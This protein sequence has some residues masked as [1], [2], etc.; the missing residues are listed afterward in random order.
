MTAVAALS[1]TSWSPLTWHA[2]LGEHPTV[3]RT[4]AREVSRGRAIVFAPTC[5]LGA[6]QPPVTVVGRGAGA[7]RRVVVGVAVGRGAREAR[8]DCPAAAR[9]VARGRGAVGVG[10]TTGDALGVGI[11]AVAMGLVA[12]GVGHG[13][14]DATRDAGKVISSSPRSSAVAVGVV[15][16][17]TAVAVGRLTAGIRVVMTPNTAPPASI[18]PHA[19]TRFRGVSCMTTPSKPATSAW[20][21]SGA[22]C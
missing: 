15:V 19:L 2:L 10:G 13:T 5:R 12:I 4:V 16:G 17:F 3:T 1:I 18:A 22:P 14:G 9:A 8:A 7:G 20:S 6:C 21:A 11:V